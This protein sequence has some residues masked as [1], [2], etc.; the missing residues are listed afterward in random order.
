MAS[1]LNSDEKVAT[2]EDGKV[3]NMYRVEA[4]PDEVYV[5]RFARFGGL[6][7]KL[8]ASGVEARGVER[9]LEEDRENKNVW[10]KCVHP[11]IPR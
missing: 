3:D 8:F 11:P 7:G 6:L 1:S 5:R 10:N 9:V 2:L 4:R